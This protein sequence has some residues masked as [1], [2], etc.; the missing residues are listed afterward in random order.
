MK[1]LRRH[2]RYRLRWPAVVL[3]GQDV[4]T[5]PQIQARIFDLSM[6]GASILSEEYLRGVDRM[7]LFLLP[8]PLAVGEKPACITVRSRLVYSVHS[9]DHMCFR[10]GLQFLRFEGDSRFLLEE[11]LA[12]HLPA[13]D[14]LTT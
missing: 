6:G 14:R 7:T 11:R 12:C 4:G 8:P 3:L 13:I 5:A 1:E 2:P 10:A 9:S